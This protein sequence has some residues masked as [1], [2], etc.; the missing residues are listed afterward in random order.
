MLENMVSKQLTVNGMT[1]SGCATK[2]ERKLKAID[3]V[4]NVRANDANGSVQVTYDANKANLSKIKQTI[5][6][7]DYDVVEGGTEKSNR[8]PVAYSQLLV[9][10]IIL[11]GASMV[12]RHLGG[13]NFF[14]YFPQ[15]KAGMSYAALFV[16]GLL[17]SVHC[18][19]M[20]GGIN[21][22]QC[23]G[24]T[25]ENKRDRLRPSFLYNLGRVIAYT[26]VG[27]V[28]GALGGVI[29]FNGMMRGAVA[30]FAGVFMIIMGLNM[31]DIFPWLRRLNLKMPRF[32]TS[33]I[34]GKSN[35]PL[36]VGLLNGLMPC[37]PLQAMQLYALSTGSPIQGATAMFLFSL[38][39][40]PL[41]FGFGAASAFLSKKFTAK[42]MAVSAVLVIMLGLGMFN[43]GLN[44]SGFMAIGTETSD[45]D[46]TVDFEP[47]MIDGYQVVTIDVSPR[48]YAPITVK[49]G[50]PVKFNLRADAKSLNGCNDAIMIPTYGIQKPLQV[51]DNIVEFTPTEAGV[52]PYSCWM[53]MIRSSITVVE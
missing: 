24:I 4:Q 39:T 48:G 41:M 18:I 17:T 1:C 23:I 38:G 31:L 21:L 7:L 30:L 32:L 25:G 53:N 5:V 2:I 20:C 43:T 19:G 34:S 27:G 37:G 29:S 26:A 13:F 22:A 45:T 15:A 42:M 47:V 46:A 36:Y 50:V 51:G 3:G 14:N 28:V 16:I 9:I 44:M 40:T 52:V 8:E 33:N 6:S 10:A 35:S 12:I 49:K 11:F